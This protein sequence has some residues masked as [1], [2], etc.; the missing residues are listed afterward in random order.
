MSDNFG[1]FNE[2]LPFITYCKSNN[3]EYVGVINIYG[4]TFT[5]LYSFNLISDDDLKRKLILL[6]E[7]W[8]WQCNRNI[9]IEVFLKEQLKEFEFCKVLLL[10]KDVSE[11][12]GP[13]VSL[14]NLPLKRIKRCNILLKPKFD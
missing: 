9:P 1:E 7:T 12:S 3:I 5:S 10:T 13:V 2:S 14:S 4:K 11:I 8:W 6:A